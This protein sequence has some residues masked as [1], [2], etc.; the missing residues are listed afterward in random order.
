MPLLFPHPTPGAPVTI[1]SRP[2]GFWSYS[3]YSGA[4]RNLNY[5][6]C[7]EYNKIPQSSGLYS[8]HYTDGA[9]LTLSVTTAQLL[10]Q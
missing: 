9:V 10:V 1:C 3:G 2:G 4:E 8:S 6:L 5:C 7:R